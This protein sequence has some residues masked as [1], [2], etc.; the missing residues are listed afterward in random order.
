MQADVSYKEVLK[1]LT[2][3]GGDIINAIMAVGRSCRELRRV[4]GIWLRVSAGEQL[5][6]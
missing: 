6:W 4:C 2:A 5:R 1:A 3:N